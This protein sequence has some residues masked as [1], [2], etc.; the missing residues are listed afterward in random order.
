MRGGRHLR[1]RKRRRGSNK[2]RPRLLRAKQKKSDCASRLVR[3][4]FSFFSGGGMW[5]SVRRA[6]QRAAEEAEAMRKQQEEE[7]LAEQRR[8]REQERAA[9]LEEARKKAQREQDAEERA[10]Q[11]AQA[12]TGGPTV[13]PRT[14]TEGVWR[15]R[16]PPSGGAPARSESPAPSPVTAVGPPKIGTGG[17]W[18]QRVA[19]KEKADREKQQSA[20]ASSPAVT[21]APLPEA[22]KDAEGFETVPEKKVWRSRRVLNQS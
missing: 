7:R 2:R 8:Q 6:E 21:H 11:R 5:N 20:G 1:S 9:S 3:V 16:A 19:E 18:R 17:N 13:V 10:R 15:S 4:S 22:K 14:T 12:K